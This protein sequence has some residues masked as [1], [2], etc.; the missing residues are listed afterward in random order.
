MRITVQGDVRGVHDAS[1]RLPAGALH[2]HIT[3]GGYGTGGAEA[4]LGTR[5]FG[6]AFDTP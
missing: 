4:T 5:R 1:P 2:R 3:R 6:P